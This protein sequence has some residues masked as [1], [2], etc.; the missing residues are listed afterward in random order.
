MVGE[1]YVQV[2]PDR[3]IAQIHLKDVFDALQAV[4]QGVPVDIEGGRALY[5]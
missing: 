1:G 2:E 5:E 4:E 3:R